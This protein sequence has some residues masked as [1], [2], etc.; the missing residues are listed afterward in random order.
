MA[1]RPRLIGSELYHHIYA[2]GNDRHPVFKSRT[3]Y[4]KYLEFLEFFGVRNDVNVVAYGLMIGHIHLFVFDRFGKLSQFMNNL[5]GQYAQYYNR[6]AGRVGHVFGERFNNK[7]VQ[8]NEYGLWL[9]RYIH[10]QAV[11]AGIARDPKNYEWTSYP[12]Y[13][14]E[15]PKGFLKP[16]VILDQFGRG[17]AARYRYEEFVMNEEE[18]P[19]DWDASY[20]SV[21][22][23]D[24]FVDHIE[25]SKLGISEERLNDKDLIEAVSRRLRVGA[26]LLLHP[27]GRT[28]R[29]LR[30]EAFVILVNSYG[31]C[32]SEVARLFG[33][34]T[35]T[36]TKILWK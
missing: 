31:L 20:V 34:C 22:G 2:W 15:V 4:E 35:K 8:T 24:E 14:G 3:H 13:L 6:S 10:R 21:V 25:K 5:H 16:G 17:Q 32:A 1:R 11:E 30:H 28:E 23:D 12:A 18:G 29:R 19:I 27:H 9:S 33:V 36:V 7:I 26:G